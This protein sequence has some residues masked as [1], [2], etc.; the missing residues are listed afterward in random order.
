M[1]RSVL[2]VFLAFSPV[3]AYPQEEGKTE[4]KARHPQIGE[5][6]QVRIESA[7]DVDI[8]VKDS[9]GERPTKHNT[10]KSELFQYEVTRAENGAAMTMRV[11]C[12][13]SE[14]Q[15][16][17]H[18]KPLQ[19]G[20]TELQGKSFLVKR[21]TGQAP[22]VTMTD[23]TPAIPGAESLGGWEDFG[24]LLPDKAVG[25]GDQ[26]ILQKD[27]SALLSVTNMTESKSAQIIAT[28]KSADGTR[29][30][31]GFT[32][33]VEGKAR[34]GASVKVNVSE[35]EMVFDS[36]KGRPVR[37]SVK[38]DFEMVKDVIHTYAKPG[39]PT[40]IEE[41]VGEIRARSSKLEVRISFE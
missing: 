4:L 30:T 23:G 5:R 16:S 2:L 3:A 37:I 29:L 33:S 8:I 34:D 26:W 41:R 11:D 25:L 7:L 9:L 18:N 36:A 22:A 1:R 19:K 10:I 17:G 38:G 35:G 20:P 31:I 32:G 15:T 6:G 27:V 39:T 24:R 40:K 13:M 21:V 12:S 28:L 14:L